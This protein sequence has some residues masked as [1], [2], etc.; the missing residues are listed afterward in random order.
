MFYCQARFARRVYTR[1]NSGAHYRLFCGVLVAFRLDLTHVQW[2]KSQ[3]LK[4]G[5]GTT[6]VDEDSLVPSVVSILVLTKI[7]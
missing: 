4:F 2:H 5:P 7:P 1:G 6:F 3:G